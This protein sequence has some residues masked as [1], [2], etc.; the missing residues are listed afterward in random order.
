[1]GTVNQPLS[2]NERLNSDLAMQKTVCSN[3]EKKVKSLEI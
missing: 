1:M 2:K 3:L